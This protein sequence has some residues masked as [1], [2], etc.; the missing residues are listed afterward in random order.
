M[1]IGRGWEQV[2][3][4]GLWGV[5]CGLRFVFCVLCSVC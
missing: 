1:R 5:A 4:G 3:S 2:V